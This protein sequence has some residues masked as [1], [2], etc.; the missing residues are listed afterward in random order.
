MSNKR[1]ALMSDAYNAIGD[2]RAFMD[3]LRNMDKW[4]ADNPGFFI[5][6]KDLRDSI[7]SRINQQ[8]NTINGMM[9]PKR[10][11]P[12]AN[13]TNRFRGFTSGVTNG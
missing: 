4:N 6:K 3:K 7:R 1:S 13:Y 11:I 12:W 8:K 10:N 2:E 9:T 5:S